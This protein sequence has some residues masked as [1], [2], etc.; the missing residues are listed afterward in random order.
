MAADQNDGQVVENSEPM[1][2]Q[3]QQGQVVQQ[4][5]DDSNPPAE[6]TNTAQIDTIATSSESEVKTVT[7]ES[8]SVMETDSS[9]ENVVA[10]P[11]EAVISEAEQQQLAAASIAVSAAITSGG[12]M[13]Y[14]TADG[15]L[16]SAPEGAILTN[17]GV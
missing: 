14:T 4:Q 16:V 13:V 9:A 1:Q 2:V 10:A 15:S 5:P 12:Q 17:A 8:N 3:E 7:S 11:N 6:A